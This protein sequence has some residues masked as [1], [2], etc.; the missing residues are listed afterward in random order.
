MPL[1]NGP[2]LG[3][4]N[5]FVGSAS[6][7]EYQG[8]G[9]WAGW[10]GEKALTANTDIDFF[11]FSISKTIFAE[12][13]C[14]IDNTESSANIRQQLKITLNGIVVFNR[15]YLFNTS[16][17]PSTFDKPVRI[18]IPA[19]SQCLIT[20]RSSDSTPINGSMILTATEV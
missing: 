20:L 12:I 18:V 5:P 10:G 15:I 19:Y 7:I 2:P 14:G 9:K 16:S 3:S 6:T 13:T 17:A 8:S 11:D 1:L 4:G